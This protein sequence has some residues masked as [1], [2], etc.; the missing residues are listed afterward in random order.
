MTVSIFE[1]YT[2]LA[3]NGT[4]DEFTL[5]QTA[6]RLG[7]DNSPDAQ[8]LK[9]LKRL[10]ATLEAVRT[11]L[12]E[13]PLVISSGYRSATVNKAIG[14]ASS[15]AHMTGLAVDFTAPAF[16]TVLATA[17]AIAKSG[18]VFDQMIFEYG[19]WVHLAIAPE[20][21]DPRAQLLSIGKDHIY[22]AG[23]RVV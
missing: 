21:K 15:S 3:H 2:P 22:Q 12:G 13:V 8:S 9:N 18:I 14:G 6:A 1:H 11:L 16:G 7:L 19:R 5:S 4:R 20:D 17:K 23:L 10:A